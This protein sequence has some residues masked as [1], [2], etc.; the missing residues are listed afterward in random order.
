MN[1][2][3]VVAV[4]ENNV[5]GKDGKM[6]WRIPEESM[7]F[8]NLTMGHYVLVGRRTYEADI[9]RPLGNGRTMMILTRDET[10][11]AK[12]CLVFTDFESA[13]KYSLDN[14]AEE[15]MVI[16][17]REIYDIAL[18]FADRI[19]ISRIRTKYEG[20]ITFPTFNEAEWEVIERHEYSTSPRF[21]T[22]TLVRRGRER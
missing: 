18:P 19:Y 8:K 1:I 22:Q 16:G 6:P 2:S 20:D 13:V 14:R 21:E 9:K 15:L 5:I 4:S 10:Y 17:G 12:G 7:H 11:R 3:I